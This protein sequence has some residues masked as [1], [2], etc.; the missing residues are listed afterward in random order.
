MS[1]SKAP[2][3]WHQAWDLYRKQFGKTLPT[4]FN[5][6]M[7]GIAVLA[8]A[9][10][11]PDTLFVTVPFIAIPFFFALAMSDSYLHHGE[12]IPGGQF[13]RYF[14]AYYQPIY[15]GSYRLIRNFLT[16]FLC[17]ILGS[18]IFGF[19]YYEAALASDPALGG[20]LTEFA[21]DYLTGDLDALDALLSGNAALGSWIFWSSLVEYGLL[22]LVFIHLLLRNGILPYLRAFLVGAPFRLI[23]A[24]YKGA[25][26]SVRKAYEKDYFLTLW[27]LYLLMIAGYVAGSFAFLPLASAMGLTDPADVAG[28]LWVGGLAGSFVFLLPLLPYYFQV[29]GLLIDKYRTA[30]SSYSMSLASRTLDE[31]K[32]AQR[33]AKEQEER[34]KKTLDDAKNKADGDEKGASEKNDGEGHEGQPKGKDEGPNLDD[35]GHSDHH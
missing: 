30:F 16:A 33:L 13:Y 35:Y 20:L 14:G 31:L 9:V 26:K 25:V 22:S 19:I 23:N 15:F 27:P 34:M 32:E 3:L 8:V 28:L 21:N 4:L 18:V 29:M 6:A 1:E 11:W 5:F 10:L 7:I 12:A 24:V 2:S 17:A